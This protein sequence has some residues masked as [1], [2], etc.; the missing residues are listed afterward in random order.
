MKLILIGDFNIKLLKVDM[1]IPNANFFDTSTSN[2]LVPRIIY[3]TRIATTRTLIDNIYSNFTNS[4]DGIRGNLTL[5]I[6]DY[7][8][9]FLII[10]EEAYKI[11]Q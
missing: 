10:Q 1:D 4:E 8:A 7:S 6:S 9:Q 5:A 11:F 2:H 3:P